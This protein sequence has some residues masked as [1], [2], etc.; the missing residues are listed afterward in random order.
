MNNENLLNLPEKING[1]YFTSKIDKSVDIFVLGNGS[2]I[3]IKNSGVR[4]ITIKLGSNFTY[5]NESENELTVGASCLNYSLSKYCLE[6]RIPNFEFLTGIPGTIG[7]GIAMN[8]GCYG[9]E[10]SDII[11]KIK[12]VDRQ[13]NILILHKK[14]IGFFYRGNILPRDLI[15]VEATFAINNSHNEN[16][17]E[18]NNENNP[19]IIRQKIKTKMD[20]IS[21]LR[22]KTQPIKEKTC[23]STFRNP[24]INGFD[25]KAW[26]L[27]DECQM[28]GYNV[29]GA[30]V[31][32]LHPNF[33]INYNNATSDDIENLISEIKTKVLQKSNIDLHL[34]LR[35]IGS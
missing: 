14:E 2:N 35:I 16:N 10:F 22:Q 26:K 24:K 3:L 33:L 30:R 18:T 9:S 23:G 21:I 1:R 31:S 19:E 25:Y 17:N 15:F 20:E 27:I 11:T 28:R 4:G 12:A 6:K 29:G 8:A 7:G 13:G 32:D 34:E 5:I